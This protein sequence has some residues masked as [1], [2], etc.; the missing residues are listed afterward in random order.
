MTEYIVPFKFGFREVYASFVSRRK[1]KKCPHASYLRCHWGRQSSLC[2]MAIALSLRIFV[3]QNCMFRVF[4]EEAGMKSA[5]SASLSPILNLECLCIQVTHFGLQFK[6][7]IVK[8]KTVD[9]WLINSSTMYWLISSPSENPP[10][11]VIILKILILD[12]VT[13]KETISK[14]SEMYRI[15]FA[16]HF[17]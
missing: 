3:K 17:R 2:N 14:T 8:I 1:K 10:H 15:Y 16:K 5:I 4:S 11:F 9:I 7:R 13:L 6:L 12:S